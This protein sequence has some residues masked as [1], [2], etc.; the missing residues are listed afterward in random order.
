[1]PK[2]KIEGLI[3]SLHEQFGDDLTSPQQK[4]LM[5][6]MQQHL[7]AWGENEVP[8]PTFNESL[9]MLLEE[10]EDDHPKAAATIKQILQILGDMGI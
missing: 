3:S 4:Q 1:M 6:S 2:V 5:D 9:E 10:I 7:H 8:D